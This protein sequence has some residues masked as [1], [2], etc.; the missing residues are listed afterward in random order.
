MWDTIR[1]RH[2][3]VSVAFLLYF[4][5]I[6]LICSFSTLFSSWISPWSAFAVGLILSVVGAL[7]FFSMLLQLESNEGKTEHEDVTEHEEAP[8]IEDPPQNNEEIELLYEEMETL[9]KSIEQYQKDLENAKCRNEELLRVQEASEKEIQNIRLEKEHYLNELE[10]LDK[11]FQSYKVSSEEAIDTERSQL[12]EAMKTIAELRQSVDVK[13][14]QNETLDQKIR[15]LTYEIKTLLQIAD[16]SSLS[17]SDNQIESSGGSTISEAAHEYQVDIDEEQDGEGDVHHL[18]DPDAAKAQLKRCIDIAQKITGSQ[19]FSTH[20]SRFGDFAL[21]SYALDLRR[22]CDSLR[23]ETNNTVFVYSPKERRL[24]FINNQVRDLLGWTP[25]KFVQ[26]FDHIVQEGMFEWNN[27]VSQ[28]NTFN[29]SQT[30]FVMKTKSGKDL[31]IH[32]Q[33]GLI[34]T[35][36]FKSNVIGVLHPA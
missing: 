26:D 15:D 8:D 6:L 32:C 3:F 21:D 36:V 7:V 2:N 14:R 34:P 4:L 30:R 28:L 20:K 11:E 10:D 1:S 31:L 12:Q 13:Q 18:Q 17:G 27:S 19:H 25:D 29:Q 5:P 16:M 23:S 9:E 35:G 24:L 22:L 33:L